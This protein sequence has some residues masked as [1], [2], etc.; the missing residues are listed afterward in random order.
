MSELGCER[1]GHV[2]V[3]VLDRPDVHN[4]RNAALR[5]A[6][7]SAC[8]AIDAD[9]EI[10][11]VVLTGAGERAFCSGLDLKEAA[12]VSSAQAVVGLRNDIQRVA[13][14][15][16]PVIAAV[17]GVAVGGGLELALACDLRLAAAGA[18]LGLTEVA[19]GTIPGNG[20]T[21]RLARAIGAPA[22]LEL[23][24]TASLIDAPRALELGIV[25]EIC[26]S[27]A[28]VR[29]RALE[30]AQ[31]IA[32]KAPLATRAAKQAVRDGLEMPL[33]G[34]LALERA[35]SQRLRASADWREGVAAFA[36]KRRPAWQ[37][38]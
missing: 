9:D 4:A 12:A 2:A 18:R 13:D 16:A 29:E 31:A 27:P 1:R 25:S 20:G 30:L 28:A 36:E 17:N 22:A 37:G 38:R 21:Q 26:E 23:L 15:R 24:L 19:R 35:L 7:W 33:S 34:G 3:L 32:A 10:R 8:E 11:A 6:L 14:V 5:E